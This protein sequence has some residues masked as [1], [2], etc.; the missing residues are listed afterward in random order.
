M[1]VNDCIFENVIGV[2]REGQ[3]GAAAPPPPL[4]DHCPLEIR[5]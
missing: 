1:F 3:E 5:N 2:R 4:E